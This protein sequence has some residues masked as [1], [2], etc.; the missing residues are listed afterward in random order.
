MDLVIRR[1]TI[2][3]AVAQFHL[4]QGPEHRIGRR[5]IVRTSGQPI[6]RANHQQIA[7]ASRPRI[8]P[9]SHPRLAGR[10]GHRRTIRTNGLQV[11]RISHLL[12]VPRIALSRNL[13]TAPVRVRIRSHDQSLARFRAA[14]TEINFAAALLGKSEMP[15]QVQQ[16]VWTRLIQA[17]E[18]VSHITYSSSSFALSPNYRALFRFSLTLYSPDRNMTCISNVIV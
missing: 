2:G 10:I 7:R 16:P 1:D 13:A 5:A 17:V 4:R 6:D 15:R 14:A 3:P 12:N 11:G 9:V 18:L 8:G